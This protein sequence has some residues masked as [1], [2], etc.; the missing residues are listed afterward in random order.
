MHQFIEENLGFSTKISTSNK[1]FLEL[2]GGAPSEP[3]NR[4]LPSARSVQGR[5]ACAARMG[6]R[7]AYL[8][9]CHGDVGSVELSGAGILSATASIIRVVMSEA[10]SRGS[11]VIKNG[12]MDCS[13]ASSAFRSI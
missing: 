13:P 3:G 5:T 6:C 2:R 12:T 8:G 10:L 7:P 11:F 9:S 4:T 1:A